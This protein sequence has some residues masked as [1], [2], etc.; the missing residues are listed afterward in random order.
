MTNETAGLRA[1][2]DKAHADAAILRD[3]LGDALDGLCFNDDEMQKRGV[4]RAREALRVTEAG[5]DAKEALG[6]FY[7]QCFQ[8]ALD[9]TREQA[10][11][12]HRQMETAFLLLREVVNNGAWHDGY[13]QCL[14][15]QRCAAVHPDALIKQQRHKR[16]CLIPR[17]EKLLAESVT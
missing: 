4:E 9:Y 13:G 1:Q 15:C 3:A 11:T 6:Q 16:N 7:R 5:E 10:N 2:L 17:V 8:E 14:H 12:F